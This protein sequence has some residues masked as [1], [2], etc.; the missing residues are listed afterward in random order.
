MKTVKILI[1]DDAKI[2]AKQLMYKFNELGIHYDWVK[3]GTYAI[4]KIQENI[5]YHAIIMDIVMPVMGGFEA[6]RKIRKLGFTKPIIGRASMYVVQGNKEQAQQAGMDDYSFKDP[7]GVEP[8]INIL[9][10]LK[11]IQQ[12]KNSITS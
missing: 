11:V 3:T 10:K 2:W 8:L 12:N 4:H 6:T 9:V 1:V 5:A 7:K